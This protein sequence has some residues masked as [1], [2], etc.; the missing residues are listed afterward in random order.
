MLLA[1]RSL[2]PP[3]STRRTGASFARSHDSL[4]SWPRRPRP[5]RWT[6]PPSRAAFSIR[7]ASPSPVRACAVQEQDRELRRGARAMP[8]GPSRCQSFRPGPIR[9]W[10]GRPGPSRQT[11]AG[12]SW[13][14]ARRTGWTW[15]SN[16]QRRRPWKQSRPRRSSPRGVLDR[17]P[18]SSA[19]GQSRTCRSTARNFLELA[20]PRARATRRSR[21]S[22]PPRRTA[23]SISSAGQLGRGGNIT[24]D[25]AGQQRRRGGRAARRTC[26]RTRCRSSRSRP[27]ASRRSSG[28]SGGSA[29]NV[30][31]RSGADTLH[32]AAERL[33]ARRRPAGR[34]RPRPTAAR[35]AP[36]FDRQQYAALARRPA[37]SR[38]RPAGSR[39]RRV[40]RPGR[41]RCR[42]GERDVATPHH[43]PRVR[44]RR[45]SATSSASRAVDWT[46]V[47]ARH[48]RPSATAFEDADD[49]A[50]STLDRCDRLGHPAPGERT[51]ATT[52]VLGSW[53]RRCSAHGR[54]HAA[55]AATAATATQIDPVD[56]RAAQLTFPSI[57][58]GAS[59]RVPQ[60]TDP[61]R[62]ASSPTPCP[63]VR[64]AHAC[65]V[66]GEV[67]ST[68]TATSTSAS[69]ATGRVELVQD[70]AQLRPEPRRPRGR[71]RPAVRGD[72]AERLAR[73]E[74]RCSTTAAAR[75]LAFFV[76]DDWRVTPQLTLNLGL[77]YEVD[78]ERQEH[79]RL[80]TT[81]TRSCSRSCRATGSATTT[82]SARASASTGLST[83][84]GFSSTAATG[85]YYDRVTL[86]I[87][88]LERGLDGARPADRGA[89]G[90]RVLPRSRRRAGAALRADASPIP[91]PASSCPGAGRAPAS[92]SS[93]TRS[94]TPTVQQFNLGRGSRLPRR[95]GA[96]AS[97]A[98][99]QPRHALHHRPPDRRGLQPR[100]GRARPRGRTWSRASDTQYDAAPGRCREALAA[101]P[102][103]AARRTRSREARNYA[104]DD[105]IPF[106]DR[107]RSTRT[108]SRRST[109]R[110]RTSSATVWSLSR[111][112]R[113]ARAACG[114]RALWTIASA[115]ADGHPDARRLR[116]RAH[117][118]AQRGRPRVQDR[119]PSS[120]PTSRQLNASG[121]IDGVPLPLV[122]DDARFSDS[123]DSLDL[124]LSRS[125]H[126]L[127]RGREPRGHRRVLQRVQRHEH[128]RR[129][130][131]RTTR[132]TRTCWRATSTNPAIPASCARRPSAS[133]L[134]TRGRRLRLGRPA[135]V[136]AR[137]SGSSSERARTA[138]PGR[139]RPGARGLPHRRGQ[140]VGIGIFLTPRTWRVS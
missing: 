3:Y 97:T 59:F 40:P 95:L 128:P 83:G 25:G 73:P 57:Q 84:G 139:L 22:I 105:Q 43:P 115:R 11:A 56:A 140:V 54:Q 18:A 17:R 31:T 41:R 94:R 50:P 58:D 125:V 5:R 47:G 111:L 32:G 110:R 68:S 126:A 129:L 101:R 80:R 30:V 63:W 107:A 66:G 138:P 106:C 21:T 100:R 19:A 60:G 91:S 122:G 35:R 8:P 119:R 23:S 109:A 37:S 53:T 124:R 51:T 102:A 44:A 135:A 98:R 45:P 55:R 116:A 104:N 78:T 103:A 72:A 113:A 70:F 1:R 121:G 13:Q 89:G 92:T 81:S 67:L 117:A 87:M 137:G 10:P 2:G 36:P 48:A 49:T 46:P 120:T 76:Q 131:Q 71:Q 99:A 75:Y 85:I 108:T 65:S 69:S 61:G 26:P 88:S 118:A 34:C 112:V 132:A 6:R 27:T 15:R 42:S 79:L 12:W 52:P 74:P 16:R 38:A 136:P 130:Q 133:A 9:S 28:R 93:T 4:S 134:T 62:A 77:R 96:A 29:I 127:G 86:E 114:S 64:G 33:P 39:R 20:L 123:F 24:I 14:S 90:Q 82:T 7:N